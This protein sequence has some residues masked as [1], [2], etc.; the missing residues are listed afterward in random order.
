MLQQ[1]VPCDPGWKWAVTHTCDWARVG[2][3]GQSKDWKLG[4]WQQQEGGD[5]T[6]A[7]TGEVHW[8]NW[9]AGPGLV[10]LLWFS[11]N[12]AGPSLGERFSGTL[13]LS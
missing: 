6:P 13:V 12:S 9:E 4:W 10:A 8:P 1:D 11:Q 2:H 5:V 7:Q 3:A